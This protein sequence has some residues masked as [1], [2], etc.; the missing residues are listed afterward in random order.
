MTNIHN[1]YKSYLIKK[2][3]TLINILSNNEICTF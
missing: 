3:N 1:N 2:T